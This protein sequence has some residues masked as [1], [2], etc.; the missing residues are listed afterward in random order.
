MTYRTAIPR[1][2]SDA[3]RLNDNDYLEWRFDEKKREL[4]ARK[5]KLVDW[6]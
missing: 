1:K 2:F 6:D 4:K 5:A 3:M